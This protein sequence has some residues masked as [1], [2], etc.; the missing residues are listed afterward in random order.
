MK[1]A[2][3]LLFLLA[4]LALS[5]ALLYSQ[6]F[7]IQTGTMC[8]S[9]RDVCH[10]EGQTKRARIGRDP[11]GGGGGPPYMKVV[12]TLVV[13]LRGINFG[14]WSHLGLHAKKYKNIYLI[15]IFLV[16]FIYSIHIMQVFSFVCVL[17]WSLLGAK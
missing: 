16:R 3:Y 6:L 1:A 13:S 14:F 17:T 7:L 8:P 15:C 2:L 4:N 9:Y 10:V 11:G 12:G 5:F